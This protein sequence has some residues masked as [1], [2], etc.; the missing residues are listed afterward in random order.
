MV[1]Q[2]KNMVFLGTATRQVTELNKKAKEG[3]HDIEKERG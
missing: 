2:C 1:P 3:E